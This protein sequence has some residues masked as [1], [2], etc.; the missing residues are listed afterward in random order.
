MYGRY[1]SPEDYMAECEME[2]SRRKPSRWYQYGYY[3]APTQQVPV[4]QFADGER[5]GVLM[6]WGLVPVWANGVPTKYSTIN[7]TVEKIETGPAWHS[8]WKHGNRCIMIASGFYEWQV[9]DDGKTKQPFYIHCTD[10][11][12]FGFAALWDSSSTEAGETIESCAIVTLPANAFRA[13]IHNSR[14]RSPRFCT[15]RTMTGG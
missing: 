10:Q 11:K 13:E 6:R 5:E 15:E 1:V 7:A 8:A 9:M 2:I 14:Q 3:V 4:V 12:V